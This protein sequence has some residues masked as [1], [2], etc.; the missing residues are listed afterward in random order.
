MIKFVSKTEEKSP[1]IHANFKGDSI[2]VC[3]INLSAWESQEQDGA[4]TV[5]CHFC[6]GDEYVRKFNIA[7]R[8]GLI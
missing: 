1:K 2:T 6:L 5:D 8:A 3:G 4:E 7:R